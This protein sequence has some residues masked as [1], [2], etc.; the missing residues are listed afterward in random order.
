MVLALGSFLAGVNLVSLELCFLGLA[1]AL[2]VPAVSW[3]KQSILA[4]ALAIGI[5]MTFWSSRR[6]G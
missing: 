4:A 5:G 3:L 2:A 1:L 6:E